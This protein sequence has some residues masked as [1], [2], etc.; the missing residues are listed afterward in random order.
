M[1]ER[2][3]IAHQMNNTSYRPPR[4]SRELKQ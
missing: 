4:I 3:I 2:R 1:S